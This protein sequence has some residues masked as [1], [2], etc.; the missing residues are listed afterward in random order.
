M[1]QKILFLPAWDK[2]DP[3]PSKNLGINSLSILF[4]LIGK[5]GIIEFE[6]DTNWY[7]EHVM[8]ERLE[9]IKRKIE[10]NEEA[11]LIRGFFEPDPVDL[12]YYSLSRIS[13]DDVYFETGCRHVFDGLPCYFGYRL[14]GNELPW[15]AAY[16]KLIEKG[17]EAL[18]EYLE[19]Y[20]HEIFG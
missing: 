16:Q 15:E 3:D 17:N 10:E 19:N 8:A 7:P 5:D 18:W 6:L 12:C 1:E 9:I 11:W 20:Y 4:Q 2:R 14:I 13:K